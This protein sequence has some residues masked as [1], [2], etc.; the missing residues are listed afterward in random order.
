MQKGSYRYEG[1]QRMD[2]DLHKAHMAEVAE[3]LA[4]FV[5][6][7]RDDNPARFDELETLLF[8]TRST[9]TYHD[10]PEDQRDALDEMEVLRQLNARVTQGWQG[11]SSVRSLV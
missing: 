6:M 9:T 1:R 5:G 2:R 8:H 10:L 4:E 7:D 11:D 3:A